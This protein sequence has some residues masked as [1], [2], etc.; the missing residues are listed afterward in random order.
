MPTILDRHY[1][2]KRLDVVAWE[3]QSESLKEVQQKGGNLEKLVKQ[4]L[5]WDSGRV[6]YDSDREY[7]LQVDSVFP[8]KES[9][10][11]IASVTYTAPDTR[12]HSNENKLQLKVGELSLLKFAFPGCR[13]VLILG[14][15]EKAWLKYVLQAFEFFFDEVIYLWNDE[16][17]DRLKQVRDDPKSVEK[18]HVEFWNK[19]TKEWATID[20]SAADTTPPCGLLRYKI[21]DKIK[22]Q[23]PPVNHPDLVNNKIAALCLHRSKAK[24]GAEWKSFEARRWNSIEQSR[25]YFNPQEAL[26]EI[27]LREAGLQFEGG[28]AEDVPVRS[29]LHDLGMT[30]T[31]LSEDFLLYS[32]RFEK[33]VYLQCKASGG[34]RTQHGKNIQNRTKEQVTRGIFYRC[35]SDGEDLQYNEKDFIWVSVLDGD[36]GVTKATPLK[37]IHMLE[38]A[39]YDRYFCAEDLVDTNLDPLPATDSPLVTYLVDE[40]Q[41]QKASRKFKQSS[42]AFEK[43]Q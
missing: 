18:S 9:P 14:G 12:G 26:V 13:V 15:E 39:G 32:D 31:L 3:K 19:L 17:L 16:G 11:V 29:L 34:G 23:D 10:E 37:Y 33:P 22:S 7:K 5:Q 28:I 24:G 27:S 21:V 35:R 40:L 1:K 30:H 43:P 2:E 38:L 6:T 36:W 4:V 41:C 8:K 25:N 42:V 20:L